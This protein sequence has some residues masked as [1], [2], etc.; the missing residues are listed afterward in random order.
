MKI[1]P[2]QHET[3]FE[4][5]N[6]FLIQTYQTGDVFYNWPQ[7][8]W[9][10]MHFHPSILSLDRTRIGIAEENGQIRGVV[11]FESNHA[12][13]FIQ[14]HPDFGQLKIPLLDYGEET[15]FQG[16]SRSTGRLIRV[17]FVNE[18][19]KDLE[20]VVASRG[21]EKWEKYSEENSRYRLDG[22][23]HPAQLPEGFSLKSLADENDLRKIN[24]VLWRGFNHE[25]PPPEEEVEGRA[26]CQ[27]APNFRK[28][29][30]IVAVAPDGSFVSF[31]GMWYIPQHRVAYLEPLA[32]DPD[33]RRMGLGKAVVYESMRRV[34]ALGATLVWV[35][36][37][38]EFYTAIGFQK[39]FKVYPWVKF[40]D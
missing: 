34:Q 26:F 30:T 37:G 25:G 16:I 28:D 13:V 23:I 39:I 8:R 15:N 27:Q 24:H 40:L 7:M 1:K 36:S 9:E 10:Y 35:G 21:Y 11:H 32:T 31:C 5:V 18:F 17:V 6:Q 14:V 19:D 38:Q 2:Y 4:R 29:L 3:D 20:A 33:F 22:V 12:E